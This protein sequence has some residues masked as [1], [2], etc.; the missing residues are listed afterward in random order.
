MRKAH[1]LLLDPSPAAHPL[2]I[3]SGFALVGDDL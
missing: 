2:H 3:A 1:P